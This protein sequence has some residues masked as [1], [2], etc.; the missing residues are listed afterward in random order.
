MNYRISVSCLVIY[1]GKLLVIR[2]EQNNKISWDIPDGDSQ[3]NMEKAVIREVLRET[4]V[5][6]TNPKLIR[7]FEFVEPTGITINFLFVAYISELPIHLIAQSQLDEKI[8]EIAFFDADQVRQTLPN[9]EHTL[10]K[11]RLQIFLNSQFSENLTP[12]LVV[13]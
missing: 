4:G 6:I 10:A 7:I 5:G 13:L 1:S 11:A 2:E 12:I 9:A 8:L 3:E